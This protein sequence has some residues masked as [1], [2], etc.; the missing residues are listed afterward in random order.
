VCSI[1]LLKS[2][3]VR[4]WVGEFKFKNIIANVLFYKQNELQ[5]RSWVLDVY[6]EKKI[7]RNFREIS[8]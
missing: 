8:L 3:P 6:P 1:L 2:F 4:I 7:K 5:I